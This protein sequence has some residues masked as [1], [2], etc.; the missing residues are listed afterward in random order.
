VTPPTAA[1]L[2]KEAADRTGHL[3]D[4]HGLEVET[5]AG[6]RIVD[7]IDLAVRRGT[8]LGLVGESGSGKSV[9]S[10]ALIG[11]LPPGLAATA[12]RIEL[13]TPETRGTD[14]RTADPGLRRSVRGTSMAMVFQDSLTALNPRIPV[15][16]QV[17]EILRVR[18]GASKHDAASAAVELMERVEI[19]Q[20]AR[21]AADYPHQLSGGQRQRVLIALALAGSPGLLLADEP[22]TA[23]DVTVQARVLALLARLQREE[24]LSMLLVSHDL[25]VMSHV[26]HDLVVMYAG[27]AAESG[28]AAAVLARPRH[29]YTL[30]LVR[31]IP[32]ARSRAVL[33]T[34]LT[35]TPPD[36][37]ARPAGCPFHPRCPMARD[38][39]RTEV[40]RL[41]EL[42]GGRRSACHYAEEVPDA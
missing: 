3:L 29:P 17:G 28:P 40:P 22:T 33:P 36:P 13:D 18:K 27:R 12:G 16:R 23:L 38:R 34:P 9:T 5:P 35:G 39:C 20:A 1:P 4:V 26:A 10:L 21:R 11:L 6:V 24:Q 14:L 19:P 42:P 41:R 37:A 32:S 15:G 30:A 31:N 8:T 7:G 2:R 25:R